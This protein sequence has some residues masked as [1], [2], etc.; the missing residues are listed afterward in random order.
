M[1]GP[2]PIAVWQVVEEWLQIARDDLRA[3]RACC[4]LDPPL[5]RVAAYLCQQAA[6]KVLKGFHV[7][8]NVRFR[9]T[10]D[11]GALADI[12]AVHFPGVASLAA[13]TE[14]WTDWNAV[15]RY[16][17]DADVPDEPTPEELHGAAR[18]Q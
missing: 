15:Y 10:H 6:E 7:R 13:Q 4:A 2:D 5:T 16:P 9:R 1:S 17:S 11:L 3:M 12:V 18:F 14:I 8:A